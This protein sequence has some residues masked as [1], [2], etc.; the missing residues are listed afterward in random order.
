[1][2]KAATFEEFAAAAE[3]LFNASPPGIARFVLKYS[4]KKGCMVLKVTDSRRVISF[5][6]DQ[7][8]DLKKL[9]KLQ[10]TIFTAATH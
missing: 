2:V 3:E 4:H 8:A 6:T 10:S 5:E 7:Q 1:M 9:E